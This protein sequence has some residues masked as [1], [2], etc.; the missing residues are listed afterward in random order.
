MRNSD[1]GIPQCSG[2]LRCPMKS[3]LRVLLMLTFLMLVSCQPI[4]EKDDATPS[5]TNA[6]VRGR[7]AFV[8]TR[9]GSEDVFAMKADGSAHVS[10]VQL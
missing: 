8:S 10:F 1:S 9:D 6:I 2:M 4:A 3:V 5:P 7:L